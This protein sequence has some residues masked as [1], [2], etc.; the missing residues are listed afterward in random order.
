MRQE[1]G[2]DIEDFM[3]AAATPGCINELAWNE[4]KATSAYLSW[5]TRWKRSGN[6]T[7]CK[8]SSQPGIN[9]YGTI[10]S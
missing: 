1:C 5:G 3:L 4:M 7:I 9:Y 8:T 10:K 2:E 6:I